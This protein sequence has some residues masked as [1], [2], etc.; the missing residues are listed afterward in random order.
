MKALLISLLSL[1]FPVLIF[2]QYKIDTS[3]YSEALG[4]E[5]L[6]DV[7][8]PPGYDENPNWHFPV[9]YYLHYYGGNQNTMNT[10]M[11]LVTQMINDSLIE[12]VIM[13]GADNSPGPLGGSVYANSILWG[14][15]EDYMVYDLV[16]WIDNTFRTIEDK[17]ARGLYGESMGGYGAFRYG[18]LH[19]DVYCALAS[20][21]GALNFNDEFFR[22]ESQQKIKA[23][24]PG[25]PPYFYTCGGNRLS[26]ILNFLACGVCSP[27]TN[28]PQNY[29][30]P[31]VVQ[32]LMDENGDYIDSVL[33]KQEPYDA[34]FLIDSL[35]V[36][37]SVGIFFGDGANDE[38]FLY[39]G[40]L[41]LKD[42]LDQRG[43]PYQFFNYNGGH[44]APLQFKKEALIFLDSLL[45]NP[46]EQISNV[47]SQITNE[48]LQFTC[49]PNP[50]KTSLYVK[51]ELYNTEIIEIEVFSIT[52]KRIRNVSVK[53]EEKGNQEFMLDIQN[54]K[55]GIYLLALRTNR[56]L[57]TTRF[58]KNQ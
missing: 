56:G 19:N 9:I 11:S 17:N 41:A 30:S 31:P 5:K 34:I 47:E 58:V 33:A 8:F 32:F 48:N 51:Y 3:F 39:P 2:G 26:T 16:Q 6:V 13:V 29:I 23:E 1:L 38:L 52:G 54:L 53:N 21:A 15:Y 49:Y 24:N 25:G 55:N 40:T 10:M 44:S 14:N 36:A 22:A 27:D 43:I 7:Y 35:T 37:D 45:T 42:T 4:E 28:T 12:P 20:F 57:T 18:I 50:C 46:G